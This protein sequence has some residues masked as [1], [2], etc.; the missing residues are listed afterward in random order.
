MKSFFYSNKIAPRLAGTWRLDSLFSRH[1]PHRPARYRGIGSTPA[2]ATFTK[3]FKDAV[4]YLPLFALAVYSAIYLVLPIYLQ[5]KE[6]LGLLPGYW[7]VLIAI[8]LPLGLPD[9][10][11]K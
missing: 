4:D 11:S 7:F 1:P 9:H 6:R 10:Q 3:A 8:T 2:P 5:K